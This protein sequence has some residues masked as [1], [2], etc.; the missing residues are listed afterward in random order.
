MINDKPK[1][2]VLLATYNGINYI[3]ELIESILI[4]SYDNW[5]LIISDDVSTDATLSSIQKYCEKY[6]DKIKLLSCDKKHGSAKDN[7]MYMLSH[8][9]GEYFMFCDQDDVWLPDKIKDTLEIMLSEEKND[10][11]LPVLV[12]SDLKVVDSDL[13]I[14]DDSFMH[15][16]QLSPLRNELNNLVIQNIVTGCTVMI[17]S[18]LV[19]L[20]DFNILE[21]DSILMHDWYLALIA[22]AFGHIAYLPESTILYRQHND[23]SVG[24]KRKDLKYIINKLHNNDM[25]DSMLKT[26]RQAGYFAEL[27]NSKLSCNDYEMCKDYSKLVD[28]SKYAKIAC[29]LKYKIYK[30]DFSRMVAQFI[31]A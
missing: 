11:S 21:T 24:A 19:D 28:M 14:I 12:H 13:N 20:I 29:F 26:M 2:T 1:V 15:Y 8:C 22:S 4:Q 25:K 9:K 3:D 30:Y 27:Y 23:N 18:S 16:C 10:A 31:W 5:E 6:S 7:F 17:N